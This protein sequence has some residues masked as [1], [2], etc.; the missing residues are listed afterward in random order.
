MS[1]KKKPFGVGKSLYSAGGAALVLLI[2]IFVNAILSQANLR[3]DATEDDLYSLS[4]GTREILS[5][6]EQDV[7]IKVFYSEDNVNMPVHIKTYA[8]RMLDFLS[9]YE[10]YSD[11]QVR[12]ET[13]NPE[14]DSEAE[15]WARKYG[16]R[17]I[18][19][20]TGERIYFGL[21][22]VAADQEEVIPSIDPSREAHLEYDITR[23]ISRLQSPTQPRIGI[24]SGL[25]VFGRPAMGMMQQG[26]GQ[27]P[28][29][30]VEELRKN[31]DV[32]EIPSNGGD[33]L[34]PD[35]YDLVILHYPKNVSPQ[36]LYAVDQYVLSGGNLI[37]FAD[38]FS[39]SDPAPSQPGQIKSA[40]PTQLL[41]AWGVEMEENKVVVD[42]DYATQLRNRQNQ[43]E[44]NPVW[45]SVGPDG[46][47]ADEI[48]T[49]ELESMLLPASGAFSKSEDSAY[50]YEPL[51]R[52]SK[53]SALSEAFRAQFGAEGLRRDFNPTVDQYDLAVRIQG[54]FK[55]AFPEG[56]PAGEGEA[57]GEEAETP[58]EAKGL[59]E[60]TDRATIILAAD[61][62]LLFDSFYVNRQ[63]L[64]G[65]QIA[66][67]FNDNLNFLLNSSEMLTGNE[68]LISIRS[69]GK[70]ERPFTRVEELEKKAQSRWLARE[71]E[72]VR[73]VEETNR[74]LR[75]L[76]GQK[77]PSQEFIISE[78]QEAE[79]E[80]FQEEK[81]R[82]QQE[83][84][85]VR[86]K[87]RADI[88]A[89]GTQLKFVNIFLV[90][91]LVSFAGL[92]YALYRRKKVR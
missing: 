90:P 35:E 20:P 66:Q 14:P 64:F 13:Y 57:P 62:D 33:P 26:Q 27:E 29:L 83:L 85:L 61:A 1:E 74:K 45:L 79:I 84:K 9:E 18:N 3:W 75:Q 10:Y 86:R 91:L 22:A 36:A 54:T 59:T 58:D 78:K 88:E 67:V 24:I 28:W 68:A 42:F 44:N 37:V 82:I 71:Q 19:I 2:L 46:L 77:D 40:I 63:S 21:V 55:T 32:E 73:K 43:V 51:I 30:F 69:R 25:P 76:E 49:A 72:L 48:T 7:V 23:I 80:K 12:V 70:F 47:N 34:S 4:E 92:G 89:L 81:R 17:S 5:D 56:K 38:P 6:M 60:G 16:V 50:S 15:D 41:S 65:F 8:R 39:V 53:N 52:S 11:G 87:L 31:H